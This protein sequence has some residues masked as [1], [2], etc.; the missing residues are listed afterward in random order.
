MRFVVTLSS[1]FTNDFERLKGCSL[2][3]YYTMLASTHSDLGRIF[4]ICVSDDQ[5]RLVIDYSVVRHY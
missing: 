2:N 5:L 3:P 1:D 4:Y